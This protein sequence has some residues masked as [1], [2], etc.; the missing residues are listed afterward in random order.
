MLSHVLWSIFL[1]PSYSWT[2]RCS[3]G[4]WETTGGRTEGRR[5]TFLGS[6][7]TL[8]R[9]VT[10]G[11]NLKYPHASEPTVHKDDGPWTDERK[12]PD[13]HSKRPKQRRSTS[14]KWKWRHIIR[15]N[16]RV[17]LNNWVTLP[18]PYTQQRSKTT[19]TH[20]KEN[21][22]ACLKNHNGRIWRYPYVVFA[23]YTYK[24]KLSLR[25]NDR[26]HKHGNMWG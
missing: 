26:F 14:N 23:P 2:E 24:L 15:W 4:G 20:S 17:T 11:L 10:V 13:K 18:L 21:C 8:R 25:L 9:G 12:K 22:R 5:G 7:L 19:N 16:P 3:E 1:L 6:W